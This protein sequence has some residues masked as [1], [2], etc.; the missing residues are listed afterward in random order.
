MLLGA[1]TVVLV[2]FGALEAPGDAL[3]LAVYRAMEIM[4]G[5]GVS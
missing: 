3:R 1:V 5:V 2:M 4:V